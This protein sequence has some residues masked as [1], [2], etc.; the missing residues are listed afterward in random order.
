MLGCVSAY[1]TVSTEAVCVLAGIPPIELV[2]DE[3]KRVYSA[4]GW[5]DPQSGKA[6]RVRHKENTAVKKIDKD[7]FLLTDVW[8]GV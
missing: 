3:C 4:T 7:P 6:L 5:I 8:R 2:V 1:C